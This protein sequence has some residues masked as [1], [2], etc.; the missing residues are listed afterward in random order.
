MT[1]HYRSR[2][3]VR[4]MRTLLSLLFTTLTLSLA[5]AQTVTT[6][7]QEDFETDG[8]GSRYTA[9]PYSI[10]NDDF[11]N[12]F[13]D[14]D[15]ELDN[16]MSGESGNWYWVTGKVDIGSNPNDPLGIMLLDPIDITGYT[17][18]DV[19]LLLGTCADNN[20]YEGAGDYL[21][22]EAQ[23][24]GGGFVIVG[25]FYGDGNN[26]RQDTNLNGS[27]NGGAPTL[28]NTFQEFTFAISGVGSLPATGSTLNLRVTT[29]NNSGSGD[30]ET[31][32]DNIRV[33]GVDIPNVTAL[34]PANGGLIMPGATTLTLT[35]DDNPI[36]KNT[37][38]IEVVEDD[39]STNP[40]NFDIS[41]GVVSVSG[42]QATIDVSGYT[43]TAGTVYEVNVPADGF[44]NSV[45]NGNAAITGDTEWKFTA[46]NTVTG[47]TGVT[48]TQNPTNFQSDQVTWTDSGDE[49]GPNFVDYYV[50]VGKDGATTVQ[51]ATLLDTKAKLDAAV[52]ANEA[53]NVTAT[54][55][56]G[57]EG[58]TGVTFGTSLLNFAID[59]AGLA[60]GTALAEG[61][62]EIFVVTIDQAG[63]I[64]VQ[65]AAVTFDKSVD[66]ATA[67][68]FNQQTTFAADNVTW[69]DALD[70]ESNTVDYFLLVGKDGTTTGN[71]T[72]VYP[73]KASLVAAVGTNQAVTVASAVGNQGTTGLAFGA[74]LTF[75]LD[76]GS[77]NS[78]A[79]AEGDAEVF[80]VTTDG[81]GNINVQTIAVTF[82]KSVDPATSIAYDPRSDVF[83]ND[84]V[85]W[86][87]AVNEE[88][89]TVDYFL[90]IGKDGTTT[91][92]VT[93]VY[94]TKASLVTAVGTNQ[95][96]T[97]ASAGG[98]QGTTGLTFG[99][100]LTFAL[101]GGAANSDA[102]AEGDVEIF[103][104]TTDA[105][106]NMNVQTIAATFDK[107]IVGAMAMAFNQTPSTFDND[108]IT[109]TDAAPEESGLDYY[110]LVGK[111]GTTTANVKAVYDTK[112]ALNA[113]VG[114]NQA[115]QVTATGGSDGGTGLSFGASLT[116]AI[117]GGAANSDAL[118][119]GDAELFL[120]SVDDNNNI[121]VQTLA[122]TFDKSVDPATTI[123]F[124][125]T[126]S[127][128]TD[129]VTWTDALDEESNTVD[130]FLL[131]GKDG[132]TTGNVT[133]VYP[134]KAAI[135]ALV[136]T[137]QAV[138]VAS[139][140]GNQGTAGLTFGA[141][142]T[143]AIDGGAANSD[144]LTEGAA[145]IFLITTDAIGN[146]NVQTIAANFD[147]SVDAATSLAYNPMSTVFTNDVVTWMDASDEETP[148]IDYYVL[149]G[150]DGATTGQ[151]E[152]LFPNKAA[153]DA[154]V[155]GN[156]AINVTATGGNDG[157]T[158]ATFGAT[159]TQFAIDG[160]GAPDG[161][162]LA[163]GDVEIFVVT[164][165]A[166]QNIN[167][168]TIAAVFDKSITGV[169]GVNYA[170]S[171]NNFQS[172]VVT[173][174]D[175]F[176]EENPNFVDYYVLVGKD[177]A[178]TGQ[179]AA[180]FP[181]K[182]DLNAAVSGNEAMNVTATIG[183]EG[184]T[185]VTF[186]SSLTEFAIDG[187][188]SADGTALTDG[189]AEVFVVTIDDNNNIDVQTIAVTFDKSVDPATSITYT[190]Q[191]SVFTNDRIT[192]T[193]AV[194]EE[195]FNVNYWFLIGK[196]GTTAGNVLTVYPTVA[197]I[198]ALTGTN[199][200]LRVSSTVINEGTT[201]FLFGTL[202]FA[203]DGGSANA[204]ALADGD[205]ELF[206]ITSDLL[207]NLNV[208]TIGVTF[209]KTPPAVDQVGAV[210]STGTANGSTINAG[211]FNGGNTGVDVTVP[212]DNGDNSILNGTITIQARTT[213]QLFFTTVLPVQNITTL[214]QS[215]W[216]VSITE[217]ELQ[218]KIN[219]GLPLTDGSVLQFRALVA[220]A[221]G[222]SRTYSPSATT[223]TV[224]QT[225]P[226]ANL[227]FSL[228][229]NQFG[230][231]R[232]YITLP[233][234]EDIDLSDGASVTF[235]NSGGV[236][237]NSD[238]GN[239][240]E[241]V[242][243]VRYRNSRTYDGTTTI[244]RVIEIEG[245][246]G[247]SSNWSFN[248]PAT[249]VS[250]NLGGN[251]FDLAGNQLQTFAPTNV[252]SGD[253]TPPTYA[254]GVIFNANG[255]NPEEIT[256]TLT[257][258]IDL[259]EGAAT[260]GFVVG[261]LP[262]Q[263]AT[264]TYSG[265]GTTNTITFTSMAD[266]AW[267]QAD[268]TNAFIRYFQ[269]GTSNVR[270]LA[271][272]E[273]PNGAFE[274]ILFSHVNMTS[275]NVNNPSSHAKIGDIVTLSLQLNLFRDL[276][277]LPT[278]TI[279]G[280]SASVSGDFL[281]GP[282]TAQ[283]TTTGAN[284]E[285]AMPFTIDAMTSGG[286][287]ITISTIVTG[288]N[289]IIFDETAPT[290]NPVSISSN[291]GANT[292]QARVGDVVTVAFT[293][294]E[295]L[296]NVS[297]TIAGATASAFNVGGDN[298]ELRRTMDGTESEGNIPFTINFDD[299]A[300]N[301]GTQVT[302]V[303]DASA[304]NFDKTPPVINSITTQS[305]TN[306]W[307]TSKGTSA[308]SVVFRV[309]F[310]TPVTGV[311]NDDFSFDTSGGNVVA[312][313]NSI[314]PNSSTE[315][316]VTV[317][318]T[319]GTGP[320]E[321]IYP[322]AN[323]TI[324]D[325]ANNPVGGDGIAPFPDGAFTTG[326]IYQ[327][328]FPE[329]DNQ[330][331]GFT[332]GAITASSIQLNWTEPATA[333][334]ETH[335]THYLILIKGPS[336]SFLTP[337]DGTP[338]ANDFTVGND[339]GAVSVAA[340]GPST[341][342]TY[343][344]TGLNS[345]TEYDFEIHAYTLSA[346]NS[347]DNI[348]FKEDGIPTLNNIETTV[349]NSSTLALISSGDGA[350]SAMTTELT[351]AVFPQL[352]AE[353]NF[354]FRFDEDGTIFTDGVD[355]AD[356][357]ISQIVISQTA[358]AN[359][360]ADWTEA[361]AG[362]ELRDSDGNMLQVA[363]GPNITATTITFPGITFTPGAL[364]HIA[365]NAIKDYT[366]RIWLN[367]ALGGTLQDDI[368][369]K[370]F[371][372]TVNNAAFTFDNS[373]Q[374]S[375]TLAALQAATTTN[376]SNRVDVTR[377]QLILN[378]VLASRNIGELQ[379][380]NQAL[381]DPPSV[382]A[383]D[384]NGNLDLTVPTANITTTDGIGNLLTLPF[385]SGI[386]DFSTF[387]YTAPGNGT[388]DL[389]AGNG[390]TGT[391][392]NVDVIHAVINQLTG[393]ISGSPLQP[394]FVNKA[395]L[396]FSINAI[397]ATAGEPELQTVVVNFN[398]NNITNVFENFRLYKSTDDTQFNIINDLPVAGLTITPGTN[399]VT[400]DGLTDVADG[401]NFFVVID[402]SSF[403]DAGTP[404]I[405]PEL[406]ASN[407]TMSSG[408]I[409][410][411]ILG[412]SYTF[413][414]AIPPSVV[415]FTPADDSQFAPAIAP[416]FTVDF[417]EPVTVLGPALRVF[418]R[419][420]DSFVAELELDPGVVLPNATLTFN[421]P[422]LMPD[423]N[424]DTQYYIEIAAGDIAGAVGIADDSDNPFG[425]I[426]GNSTWNFKTADT[427]PPNYLD[428]IAPGGDIPIEVLNIT[429]VGFT[430]RVALDEQADFYY[431]VTET[432]GTPTVAQMKD[433][434]TYPDTDASGTIDI[435]VDNNYNYAVV[436]GLANSTT[437]DVWVFAEDKGM[438]QG[439]VTDAG[440]VMTLGDLPN[441]VIIQ[442]ENVDLCVSTGNFQTLLPTITIQE[443][444]DN[445]FQTGG[446]YNLALPN[447]FQFNESA[448]SSV[449][450]AAGGD[451]TG[452]SH[453]Y[454]NSTTI[455]IDYTLSGTND[456]DQ[457]VIQG[458]EIEAFG[459]P[460]TSGDI[461]KL[462]GTATFD[463][464][465]PDG[466]AHGSLNTLTPDAVNFTTIPGQTS[467]GNK[468]VEKLALVVSETLL[469]NGNA[470]FSGP[471]VVGDTL[472]TAAAGIGDHT[473]LLT[474]TSTNTSNPGCVST[475]TRDITIFDSDKSIFPDPNICTNAGTIITQNRDT[476]VPGVFYDLDSM[477][478]TTTV[479][480]DTGLPL[481]TRESADT[482]R[483][484]PQDAANLGNFLIRFH[485]AYTRNSNLVKDTLR[486]DIIVNIPPNIDFTIDPSK[487]N[488]QYCVDDDAISLTAIPS[489]VPVFSQ[490][491]GIFS[492][493]DNTSNPILIGLT[494]NTDGTGSIDPA[495][496]GAIPTIGPNLI[497]LGL[498]TIT[499]RYDYEDFTTNCVLQLD[500]EIQINSLPVVNFTIQDQ[501]AGDPTIFTDG[502]SANNPIASWE[503]DFD[504]DN[505]PLNSFQQSPT[506]TYEDPGSFNVNLKVTTDIGCES[507][508]TQQV[509][510]SGTPTPQFSLTG[511]SISDNFGFLDESTVAGNFPIDSLIWDFGDGTVV[512]LGAGS[513]QNTTNYAYANLGPYSVQLTAI[514]D[515][516]FCQ[517]SIT[518]SIYVLPAETPTAAVLYNE[519]FEG[520][521]FDWI[522]LD[523]NLVVNGPGSSWTRTGTVTKN[524]LTIDPAING[525]NIWATNASGSFLPSE[526]SYLYSPHLD[527]TQL[528]RPVISFNFNA[529]F[530]GETG[531]GVVLEYSVDDLNITDPAKDWNTLGGLQS[532]LQWYNG[533]DITAKPGDQDAGD[534]AWTGQFPGW[535]EAKHSLGDIDPLDRDKVVFRFAL[536][537]LETNP[538]VDGFA[539]DN[540]IVG[541]R[542]RVV[543]V[544]YFTNTN[545]T[546]DN[547]QR[548][549]VQTE[550]DFIDN[551]IFDDSDPNLILS[552]ERVK[553]EYHTDF[554]SD[555]PF[556]LDNPADANARAQYYNLSDIPRVRVDGQVD[557]GVSNT[558]LFEDWGSTFI[559]KRE[560]DL[561]QFTIDDI[562][563][564]QNAP[565]EI[566][567]EVDITPV[568]DILDENTVVHV[569]VLED[570]ISI[571]DLGNESSLVQTGQTDFRYIL[572]ALLPNAAGTKID[573]QLTAGE[574][575]PPI[576]VSWKAANF[577]SLAEADQQIYIAVF[578][579]NEETQEIYQARL[580][581]YGQTLDVIS[582]IED[583]LRSEGIAVYP[584]PTDEQAFVKFRQSA[585]GN[586]TIRVYDQ[587][588][589]LIDEYQVPL[590]ATEVTLPASR[591]PNGLMVVQILKDGEIVTNKKLVVV[592]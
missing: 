15:S 412:L 81:I 159:L 173:W 333:A 236:G 176:D 567:V 298:W 167:S 486:Q 150:K 575:I 392:D 24:D 214:A 65:T 216:D 82:D 559:N 32:F 205:A 268:M 26:L 204:D 511:T 224:D 418:R 164:I 257:E 531:E 185:G 30:E 274:Y 329:P 379:G 326:E 460:G 10:D 337:T 223:L 450:F 425:G 527:I 457:I 115:Q 103:L 123:N 462:G 272:N 105:V 309:T 16:D 166:V 506:H 403:V 250:Y 529:E 526:R 446:T 482:Y 70:E 228:F 480:E 110:I 139:A 188:G 522:P 147:K 523:N 471:G 351:G 545:P 485:A 364:G 258:E 179:V 466:T 52:A 308:S 5:F 302:T 29:T 573:R 360:V 406:Q 318:I 533:R 267:S 135:Q 430:I 442:A 433:P 45:P 126:T 588:A 417:D 211:F 396:G 208:Q 90:L 170:P 501:C 240:D 492:L 130:Y 386:L 221:V 393:G 514:T 319:S 566:S 525:T 260:D 528:V 284:N 87:D 343:T 592:H 91:G 458:L 445:M 307:S 320:L 472:F 366:L 275:N 94:P 131:I 495:V 373:G 548:S 1:I 331:T 342:Q 191:P 212:V 353:I 516:L 132:T 230:T 182:T 563:M 189:D 19:R 265:K 503:W 41:T 478:V 251:I 539:L 168:A 241:D 53:M 504:D 199:Q 2:G 496:V 355:N 555:D 121:D 553:L 136:G 59:A 28:D 78:D 181:T 297:G 76:G 534:F 119:E 63:N 43:F 321:L 171:P 371:I 348:D 36:T 232:E 543:L 138:T 340:V 13:E 46:D 192:W 491:E 73:T 422:A 434:G 113:L 508:L 295:T 530:F 259:T 242:V 440:S 376:T 213:A 560:L 330:V 391:L 195:L 141:A 222:N 296:F 544:E 437:Y 554:P 254:S 334:M 206:L 375:S 381:I 120:L 88:S 180:L 591:Y 231:N 377:T 85:T 435:Q 570:N 219:G 67:I 468:D 202:T 39:G 278:V 487:A 312:S 196:D 207:G 490:S 61:A 367:T 58:A 145:E 564:P 226:V 374:T 505:D 193:D 384:P 577:Y 262:S 48:F 51:V 160:A 451:I 411:D 571:D 246:N 84:R 429:D 7:H 519:D 4:L 494:D 395:I 310:D 125:Q 270:D 198:N 346:N 314:T 474:Y 163:D 464:P 335:P 79:L 197:A 546:D 350:L 17:T 293:A 190:Q 201:G 389:N 540:V 547:N 80:L 96:L 467:I 116:F 313:V 283:I 229:F 33:R 562:R 152:A 339:E 286:L 507:S 107:T 178:T 499:I 42:N 290:L 184:A 447:G 370:N 479:D 358:G 156:Q 404:G 590:G 38:M 399:T 327:I 537:S 363:P 443:G 316:D 444:E 133:T 220:D 153:L 158:G 66:P 175:A 281:N 488:A 489:V 124:N 68:M 127:F 341:G 532:G 424:S 454:L 385:N 459:I 481:V 89:N 520:G 515:S 512:N 157:A 71:L 415:S 483:F 129:N 233:M 151:V 118:A 306:P 413:E 580:I 583:D 215:S 484:D 439:L 57:D 74:S 578:I 235:S 64:D 301:A 218:N 255:S 361:I 54:G 465:V 558:D 264:V 576:Q 502:S 586:T 291:N 72:T 8:E 183:N 108:N 174:N 40:M 234:S 542:T 62:A 510:V 426:S 581:K 493:I 155:A 420:D 18:I 390:A 243:A 60:D 12:R 106:G 521:N 27:S 572:K 186:G 263:A 328:V 55:P 172:D 561:A 372:F 383:R 311:T 114:T 322:D 238:D 35:F 473:I 428:L 405:Q 239:N 456:R 336:G 117:D 513:V 210:V 37:G 453:T 282:I 21:R 187:S 378:D 369:Q 140:I 294:D 47:V 357:K 44:R 104:V 416:Q 93:T 252:S 584:N 500:K 102:L 304:V 244:N 285:G 448:A 288:G 388:I 382:E 83:D 98:S 75:A 414:D 557:E 497:P 380:I 352:N 535:P 122:A 31:S 203:I 99:A 261:N 162:A 142:L 344:W 280:V 400:F 323:S 362:A 582:G 227:P 332:Q 269:S 9:S 409:A 455:Q 22:V 589:K 536:A 469:E 271:G 225:P 144:A 419:D 431:I 402:V 408:S 315:Y 248:A 368:D 477:W 95:A 69:T 149:V 438:V 452:I 128:T 3:P 324:V 50:L 338:V 394:S 579:Q 86:T 549:N 161:T 292:A 237:I 148:F 463:T 256:V 432:G 347:S 475:N 165:D 300:D 398:G 441:E 401:D 154:A 551:T 423:L 556:N 585:S 200:A 34:Q 359:I 541:N 217:T 11:Y 112:A 524:Q 574:D 92:N 349:G 587:F 509:D 279:D 169:T 317:D 518:K 23:I 498:D 143:F 134:T 287:P 273:I 569:A 77:A 568:M 49:E 449:T 565:D 397:S 345:G 25:A 354:T 436:T 194:D 177:G 249:Q 14:G 245:P 289:I 325:A 550:T 427:S 407:I 421:M 365:D 20:E 517:T 276:T 109:W 461:I 209:D 303:T 538:T 137:N 299:L 387:Q 470:V 552:E 266:G 56:G 356:T 101:D 100:S 97:V 305:A 111:D 476:F 247:V 6:I 277:A 146:I 253:V 410:N